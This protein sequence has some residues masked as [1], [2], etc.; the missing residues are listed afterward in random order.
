MDW[1]RKP[2]ESNI[3]RCTKNNNTLPPSLQHQASELEPRRQ[4]DPS[5]NLETQTLITVSAYHPPAIIPNTP[6]VQQVT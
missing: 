3:N 4:R 6:P 2:I 1:H 5:T